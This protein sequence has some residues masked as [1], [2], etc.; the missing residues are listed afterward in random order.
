[1]PTVSSPTARN[2]RL[3]EHK[4]SKTVRRPCMQY[5]IIDSQTPASHVEEFLPL[6]Q[7][8]MDLSTNAQSKVE[9]DVW[10]KHWPRQDIP[11]PAWVVK[12]PVTGPL[13]LITKASSTSR[14]H[15]RNQITWLEVLA[16][17]ISFES[18]LHRILI[19]RRRSYTF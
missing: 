8:A 19:S 5:I 18:L 11:Q 2:R 3:A 13:R 12:V 16:L 10:S 6:Q 14:A 1:M 7:L 15:F 4:L 9:L 17:H